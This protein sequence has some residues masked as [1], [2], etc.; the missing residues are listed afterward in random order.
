M[1][2]ESE[3]Q[4]QEN[5]LTAGRSYIFNR[6]CSNVFFHGLHSGNAFCRAAAFVMSVFIAKFNLLYSS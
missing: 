1:E 4:M 2:N 3:K 5:I 6:L